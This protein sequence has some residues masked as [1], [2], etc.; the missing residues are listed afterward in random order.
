MLEWAGVWFGFVGLVGFR[1]VWRVTFPFRV[2]RRALIP[3]LEHPTV[4]GL[5]QEIGAGPQRGRL[6]YTPNMSW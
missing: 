4:A 6:P 5:V 1:L 3:G 2:Q